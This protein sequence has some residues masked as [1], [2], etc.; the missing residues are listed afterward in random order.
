MGT[1]GF[2]PSTGERRKERRGGERE[3]QPALYSST[4]RKGSDVEPEGRAGVSVCPASSWLWVWKQEDSPGCREPKAG[5][6]VHLPIPLSRSVKEKD[7]KMSA[8]FI[9]EM[10]Q[11][12]KKSIAINNR[13]ESSGKKEQSHIQVSSVYQRSIVLLH[14]NSFQRNLWSETVLAGLHINATTEKKKKKEMG[15]LWGNALHEAFQTAVGNALKSSNI[16]RGGRK[17]KSQN[18]SEK[19]QISVAALYFYLHSIPSALIKLGT[20]NK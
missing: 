20:D 10:Q 15:Q 7:N 19:P 1:G 8:L 13:W 17:Q 3:R 6:K 18:D 14:S 2:P 11:S 4:R 5:K 12:R 9:H 16:R